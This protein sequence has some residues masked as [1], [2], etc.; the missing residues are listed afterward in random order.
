MIGKEDGVI[1]V[2][3]IEDNMALGE[4]LRKVV[5]SMEDARC[6]GVWT[7]AEEGLKKI[8]AFRPDIV[9]MDIN[10]PGMSGIEATA[11]L[12]RFLPEIQVI[13]VTVHREHKKI[14]DA[15]KAGACGYL[16]KRSHPAEVREAISDVR[17]GG[18]PMSPEIA[19]R[20]VEAFHL[21]PDTDP[22]E[23]PVELSNRET[24]VVQLVAEGL[25]NKEIGDR[26]NISI[27]TV[28]GHLKNIYEKLHV[29]SRTE[30]AVKYLDSVRKKPWEK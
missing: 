1:D 25:A 3:I 4:S 22:T 19:R 11:L 5:D 10:L 18:A 14:F 29:R 2:A 7:T 24:D 30:A 26:L 12:K 27:E 21:P 16:I 9:L 20:V 6:S 8:D 15:L 17:T 23:T 13:I 28:R